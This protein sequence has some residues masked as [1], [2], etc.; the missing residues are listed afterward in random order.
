MS[1]KPTITHQSTFIVGNPNL[2]LDAVIVDIDGVLA[3]FVNAANRALVAM[4]VFRK[5]VAWTNYHAYRSECTDVEWA[6]VMNRYGEEIYSDC[7]P[8]PGTQ[9][10]MIDLQAAYHVNVVT[11]RAQPHATRTLSWFKTYFPGLDATVH[12]AGN[13]STV[14][15]LLQPVAGIDDTPKHRD[16]ML[17]GAPQA[18]VPL[19]TQPWNLGVDG[20]RV[21]SFAEFVWRLTT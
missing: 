18:W 21:S 3:D 20:D 9:A 8:L 6:S 10:A 17:A 16:E 14:A 1:K 2:A 4:K 11:A 19:H 12:F 13:K 5:P 15:A 7:D